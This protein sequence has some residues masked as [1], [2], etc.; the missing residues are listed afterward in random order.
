MAI[1]LNSVSDRPLFEQAAVLVVVGVAITALVYGAV[2]LIVKM[3]DVGLH[4]A[5]KP[6][7]TSQRLGRGLVAAMPVVLSVLTNVGTLAM[8]WVGGQIVL[9]GLHELGLHAPEDVV[10]SLQHAV[11]GVTGG[12]SG[13]LGWLT[14]ALA[15]A[16]AGMALGSVIAGVVHWVQSLRGKKALPAH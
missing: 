5:E 6:D 7:A 16:V 1:A 4:L 12:L 8:L 13:V 10:K 3:D 2:A 9:H 14:Y 15:S 11:E